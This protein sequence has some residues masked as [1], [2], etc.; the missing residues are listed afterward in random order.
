[1]YV[2]FGV[3]SGKTTSMTSLERVMKKKIGFVEALD[4]V[5]SRIPVLEAE[6]IPLLACT[7]RVLAE[8]APAKVDS[9]SVNA[10]L[11]DGYAVRSEDIAQASASS[12]VALKIHGSLTAGDG[13]NA[14]LQ[15]KRSIRV[16]TGAALPKGANAVLAG[17]FAYEKGDTVYC[18]RDAEPGR[19]VLAMGADVSK[20]DVTAQ[21][22]DELHPALVGLLAAAGLGWVKVV[23]RARICIIGTGDEVV[24]PGH[25]LPAGKLY[26][27]NMVETS[28]WLNHFG[29]N[30]VQTHVVEDRVES[31]RG[32][33]ESSLP[34]TDAFITSGGAWGSEKDLMVQ[35]L[36]DMGWEGI[37]HRVR[38]GPGKAVGFGLL[39]N[40]PVFLLPGGPPSCEAAFLLLALPGI[41]ALSGWR[42]PVF[43]RVTAKLVCDVH[44]Q[45]EWTQCV[46]LIVSNNA[47]RF[48]AEP[49]KGAS[50]LSSMAKKNGLMLLP[51]GISGLPAESDVETI[52]LG[53]WPC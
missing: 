45:A 12:P 41:M 39:E 15:A 6:K 29:F 50:R 22:G 53:S 51:E 28:A 24:A 38:L 48:E 16:T 42:K 17:E 36:E 5:L 37:F 10:S 30:E 13:N 4:L 40:R 14:E 1:L 7:G 43:P 31:I 49:I 32:L 35:L 26:A 34:E 19:N 11:K 27:S 47:G 2:F 20:G 3:F 21:S 46:H 9:P 52:L 23:R 33:I 18:V 8:D 44:G 25:P